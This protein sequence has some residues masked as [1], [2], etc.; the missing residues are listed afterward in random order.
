MCT[1]PELSLATGSGQEAVLFS[2]HFSVYITKFLRH[3]LPND[4]GLVSVGES[5]ESLVLYSLS[6]L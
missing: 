6:M 2:L 5:R 1:V 3:V 4:G